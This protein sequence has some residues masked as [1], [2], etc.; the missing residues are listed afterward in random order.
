VAGGIL[1]AFADNT[2]AR[3]V[4]MNL[5]KTKLTTYKDHLDAL[6]PKTDVDRFRR[7]LFAF[8]SVHTTWAS[9]CELYRWLYTKSWWGNPQELM[10]RIAESRAGLHHNRFKYIS[11]FYDRFWA[12]PE[13]YLK[14]HYETWFEYR[15]RLDKNTLGLGLAKCAFFAEL[16]Y[17][18]DCQVPC[19][20]VHLLK[21]FGIPNEVYAKSGASAVFVRWAEKQWH[22]LS[23]EAGVS[24]TTARWCYWDE[25]QGKLDSSYWTH[26]LEQPQEDP[27]LNRPFLLSMDQITQ[28]VVTPDILERKRP[29]KQQRPKKPK[30]PRKLLAKTPMPTKET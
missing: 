29:Q 11:Q 25:K 4:I 20:D 15:D 16:I 28:T 26:V 30:E 19:M 27:L 22:D 8:A 10:V 13:W 1:P 6:R 3:D 21:L 7:G 2:A 12:C 18:N 23:L 14:Q 24:P 9:N 17:L 5:D